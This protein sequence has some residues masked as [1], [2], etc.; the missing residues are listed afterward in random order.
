LTFFRLRGTLA[1]ACATAHFF[2]TRSA[3]LVWLSQEAARKDPPV[4]LA[5][6]R[7]NLRKINL[8]QGRNRITS[9]AV[10]NMSVNSF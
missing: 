1:I 6:P 3:N 10:L 7:R 4:H 5:R 8:F 9:P 2:S